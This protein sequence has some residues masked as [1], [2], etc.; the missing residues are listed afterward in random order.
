MV[1]MSLST[2]TL[3]VSFVYNDNFGLEALR[4]TLQD[5]ECLCTIFFVCTRNAAE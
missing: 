1:L 2:F 5:T 3:G 4:L